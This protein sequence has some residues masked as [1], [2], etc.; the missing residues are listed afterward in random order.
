MIILFF[1]RFKTWKIREEKPEEE[2]SELQ[3]LRNEFRNFWEQAFGLSEEQLGE[4][5]IFANDLFGPSTS[6]ATDLTQEIWDNLKKVL[7]KYYEVIFLFFSFL[8]FFFFWNLNFFQKKITKRVKLAGIR[9]QT[10]YS[11]LWDSAQTTLQIISNLF[12]FVERYR[13]KVSRNPTDVLK[14]FLSFF[15]FKYIWKIN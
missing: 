12:R 11:N 14:V 9:H 2:G 15:F 1:F 8:F 13:L 4:I 10:P 3:E 7:L 6:K 5:W